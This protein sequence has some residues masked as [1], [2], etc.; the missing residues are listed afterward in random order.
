MVGDRSKQKV[1]LSTGVRVVYK[2]TSYSS[3]S[4]ACHGSTFPIL[5]ADDG[6]RLPGDKF[7][8]FRND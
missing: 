8:E 1:T 2:V 6:E 4:V 3:M 7:N 5:I